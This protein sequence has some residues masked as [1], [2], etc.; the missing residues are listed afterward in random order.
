MD[1][2][3]VQF[4]EILKNDPNYAYDFIAQNYWNMDKEELANIV[5]E[6]LYAI[7]SFNKME[8]AEILESIGNE[9]EDIYS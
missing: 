5:K 4:V 7:H 8:E 2:I 3:M 6:L 9:L 1:E